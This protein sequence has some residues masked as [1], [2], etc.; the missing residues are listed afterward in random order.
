MRQPK[1]LSRSAYTAAIANS[2][3]PTSIW[4]GGMLGL[5]GA[6]LVGY[7][8]L[9]GSGLGN[10]ERVTTETALSVLVLIVLVVVLGTALGAYL[11]A[12]LIRQDPGAREPASGLRRP[13]AQSSFPRTERAPVVRG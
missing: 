8:L 1:R 3:R 4:A 7:V 13:T 12:R 2:M 10:G 11:A 5:V 9:L 6:S